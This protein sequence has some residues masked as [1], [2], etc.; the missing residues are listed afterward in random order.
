MNV[1]ITIPD[2]L[3]SDQKLRA[4]KWSRRNSG[5]TTTTNPHDFNMPAPPADFHAATG[6]TPPSSRPS[7]TTYKS[8]F[9]PKWARSWRWRG[10]VADE[11]A[12]MRFRWTSTDGLSRVL[13]D[14]MLWIS[15]L[16]SW[17]LCRGWGKTQLTWRIHS[18]R[19][20]I[21]SQARQ[22]LQRN[23]TQTVLFTWGGVG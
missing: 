12:D 19:T 3:G 22:L 7:Y 15:L 6:I 5:V 16:K 10:L 11:R 20:N 23:E 1:E 17:S 18:C 9:G 8:K 2:H 14:C 13:R 4:G 21:V